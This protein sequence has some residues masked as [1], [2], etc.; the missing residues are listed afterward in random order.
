MLI[1]WDLLATDAQ[2]KIHTCLNLL[3]EDKLI[4]DKGNIKNTY[5]Y[6]LGVYKIDRDNPE[7]WEMIRNH[8]IISFFQMEQQSGYQAIELGKPKSVEELSALNSVM[9]LMA[10]DSN[11]ES[12][13]QRYSRYQKDISLWYQEMTDYGLTQEE[14]KIIA[15]YAEKNYGLLPNQEDFMS[16]VQDP[17][18]GGMSLLWSDRL[19]KSIAK[20]QPKDYNELQQEFYQNMEDKHLSYK[21]CH[22]IWDVLISMSKG[23]GFNSA[24]TLSYSI[25]GI[26]E[27]NLAYR[28]PIIYWNT[29]NLISDSGGEDSTTNYG[30]I[31]Q[32]I[33]HMQSEGIKVTLPDINRAGYDFKPDAEKNEIL[34]GFKGLQGV[35]DRVAK[36]IIAYQ[37]YA[38][39]E[40]FYEK[41]QAFKGE[42]KENKFGNTTMIS[43]IKAGCFDELEK[44]DRKEIMRDFITKIA[45]PINSLKLSN[46]EDL[47]ELGLL[48]KEQKEYELRLYR[49]REYI[50]N[51][52]FF[53]GRKGK[54]ANT[55]YYYLDRKFAEPFFFKYFETSLEENKDYEYN[56]EGYICV[57]KGSFDRE[58]KKMMMPFKTDVLDRSD[59][60]E[61]ITQNK[62]DK[63]WEEK[64]LDTSISKWEMDSLSFYY[65]EHE[66]ANVDKEL[67]EI[68]NFNELSPKS[69]VAGF[70]AFRGQQKPRFELSRICGTVLDKDKNKAMIVLLTPDGIVNVKFYKGQ[71]AFYDKQI[72]EVNE[73]TGKKNVLERTWFSRGTKLLITGYRREEQFVPKQYRDS[74]YKHSLQL[75]TE[76]NEDGTLKLVSERA[77]AEDE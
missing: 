42:E 33:G 20:K 27:A 7:M 16:I 37:S 45:S 19:R 35:G 9:R 52:K 21:L 56:D 67:Y 32:A 57:K 34:F 71:F 2:Q 47:N 48:T 25:V 1:K 55:E 64:E 41:M 62:I 43:L 18:I 40:D 51:K 75:I 70:F 38:S 31:A 3:L 54:S 44:K 24:H 10:S 13:L 30:K 15:K 4:E 74:I 8:K 23:Y 49:F 53:A 59:M 60:L 69:K 77:G 68:V 63:I 76:I 73:D 65:H 66:L 14:Q 36:A 29:A 46:I 11:S 22:Y 39:M 50:F 58:Y 61:K 6:Y 72:S 28:Y 17:S 12:P 5:E 26:Q